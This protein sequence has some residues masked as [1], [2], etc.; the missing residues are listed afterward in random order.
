MTSEFTVGM[1]TGQIIVTIMDTDL[2]IFAYLKVST[3]IYE[4]GH[5]I[6]YKIVCAPSEDSVYGDDLVLYVP[7]NIT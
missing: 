6:S 3:F 2:R 5:S 4:P 1:A 7:F